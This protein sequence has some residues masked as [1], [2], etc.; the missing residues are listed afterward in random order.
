M[1]EDIVTAT[2]ILKRTKSDSETF[3]RN[4]ITQQTIKL[5]M[6]DQHI[7]QRTWISEMKLCL[8]T[9]KFVCYLNQYNY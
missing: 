9:E 3:W 6:L 8:R 4:L 2:I 1:I 7:H 5:H